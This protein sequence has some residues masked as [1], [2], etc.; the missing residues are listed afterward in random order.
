MFAG[1]VTDYSPAPSIGTQDGGVIRK[2]LPESY[3]QA[4]GF[5]T[6][7]PQY[8][9]ARDGFGC[10]LGGA[11]PNKAPVGPRPIQWGEIISYAL[12]QPLIAQAMGIMYLQVS[13]PIAPALVKSGGW[14]WLEIDTTNTSNWYA[15]LLTQTPTAVATYA[16]RLPALA[17]AQDVF[18]AICFP[19][20]RQLQLL[21]W[22]C[23]ERGRCYLDGFAKSS[24]LI[25]P[26]TSDSVTNN[27]GK[28]VP[29]TDTGVQIGWDDEQV[30]IWINRQIG[31]AQAKSGPLRLRVRVT[32]ELPFT[33]LGYRVDVRESTSGPWSSL[34]T[35]SGTLMARADS[36]PRSPHP[37]SASSLRRSKTPAP[38]R[39]TGSPNTSR[40]GVDARWW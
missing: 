3:L 29:G 32:A 21:R 30:T 24:T 12:R 25:S 19:P 35:A 9:T 10:A 6:P 17:I 20:F 36:A 2:D 28:I 13:I 26:S 40:S 39:T 14:I 8:F 34:C 23:P 27:N 33:V 22:R 16:A 15:K 5:Q 4:T 37:N 38:T 7:D 18:A 11:D 31:I 1:L